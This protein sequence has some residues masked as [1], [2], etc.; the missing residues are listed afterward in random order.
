MVESN[1]VGFSH[2]EI[3]KSNDH[4]SGFACARSSYVVPTQA[5]VFIAL[6]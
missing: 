2:A 1:K 4:T 6:E 3:D 5:D